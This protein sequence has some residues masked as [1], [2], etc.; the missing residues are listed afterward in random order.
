MNKIEAKTDKSNFGDHADFLN[1]SIDGKWLDEL[2]ESCYPDRGIEGTIPTL[3]F[4][5]DRKEEEEVVWQRFL[6]DKGTTTNCPILMCADDCDFYCVC[7]VAEVR[8]TG[9][10]I[11]W[12]RVGS[13]RSDV[14]DADNV[15]EETD[16]FSGFE[17]L[18]FKW[19]DYYKVLGDF[20]KQFHLDSLAYDIRNKEFQEQKKKSSK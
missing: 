6:P 16:W 2:L 11:I 10:S 20:K 19:E 4:R 14:A 8:N 3:S 5:M 17:S 13:N 9:Q 18:E 12:N 15:G 7:I 1:I